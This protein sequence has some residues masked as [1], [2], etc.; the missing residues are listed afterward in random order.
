MTGRLIT[1]TLLA[2]GLASPLPAG[3]AVELRGLDGRGGN[4][5]LTLAPELGDSWNDVRVGRLVARSSERQR[6]LPAAGGGRELALDLDAGCS[7][8]LVD[9]AGTANGTGR[10]SAKIAYCREASDPAAALR[11]RLAVAG[12][13]TTKTGGRVEIRPLRSPTMIG[14]GADLPVIVYLD[15]AAQSGAAVEAVGPD[16]RRHGAVT[17]AVGAATF[18]IS[19]S[20]SWTVRYRARHGGEDLVAELQFEVPPRALWDAM[21]PLMP[22]A[23]PRAK[24]ETDEWRELGPAPLISFG[25]NT[26]RA[27]A[28]VASADRRNRYYVGGASGGVWESVDG[29]NAWTFL[30]ETLPTLAIGAMALDP[31]DDKVIYAG[32]GE[33][34]YSYHSLYGLGLY[35]SFNRGRT[36]RVLA[37]ELFSGR[38][39]SRIVVSPFDDR[40]IWAAVA[41]AGG[42]FTRIEGAR[43]HPERAGQVGLFRSRDRGVTWEH[44]RGGNGLA[45]FPASDVD[46]D[47]VDRNRVYAAMG[48]VY[49]RN[50][51]GVYRSTDGGESFTP[52]LTQ[53]S[54]G[55]P[56]G[57]VTVAVAPSD[58]DRIYALVTNPAFRGL[59]YGFAPGEAFVQALY[60]SDDGGS[61]WTSFQPE[62]FMGQQGQYNSTMIVAPDEPDTVFLG[63]VLMLRST[64]GGATFTD[65]TPIHVD[66]HDLTFDAIGRLLVAN[67]GGV[68]RSDDLGLT[69]SALNEGLGMVQIYAGLSLHPLLPDVVLAGMQDN[70]TNL[71]FADGLEWVSIFGGDGGYTA[72]HPEQP[73]ILFVQFQGTDNLFRSTD[74]AF[75]FNESSTGIAAGDRNC[76]LPPF[77]FDPGDP[78]RMLYATQRV[79]ESTDTGV[80]WRP[81][82]ADLTGGA[83]FAVR[84]LVIAPSNANVVYAG[85]NDGR[86][87]V[88]SNAGA[89]FDLALEGIAGWPRVT[90]QIAVDP[91]RPSQAYVA[92]MGFGGPKLL[93]TRDRGASWREIGGGLPDVPV[94]TV[95]VHRVGPRRWI[96]AGSDVGVFVSSDFGET[97]EP[98]GTLPRAP[99]NDL[100]VDADFG[101]LVASTLGRGAWSIA[102]PGS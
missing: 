80:T 30:G 87:L 65:V 72:I 40:V 86:V 44:L 88:S 29:G 13:M 90:R 46:L 73:R 71:R 41:R 78:S 27:A 1:L 67:D 23:R 95:A 5:R 15:N 18:A 20:G 21:P 59:P 10:H 16:G 57:R 79:Y 33:A 62:N 28:I 83:P 34:N 99:V 38:A 101:R 60:R 43:E 81:I 69:W 51:N 2:I 37:P 64:D 11:E 58:P 98:Y 22:A 50:L 74:G 12:L 4:P 93:A 55:R 49:G 53:L 3:E 100:V 96:F 89:D 70:G 39:F 82:S 97:W 94:N 102:L 61:T 25:R 68:N 75:N 91:E 56:F 36:W 17:D 42:T 52:V 32:S 54:T 7:L 26:G 63:G 77:V 45:A 48:D 84:S 76:F 6:S 35:R 24:A 14:P 47:R 85:T 9:V 66:H 19:A 92:D 8:V 31:N